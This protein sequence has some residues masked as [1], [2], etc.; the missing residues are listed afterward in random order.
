MMEP[1]RCVGCSGEV[2]AG[3]V[4]TPGGKKQRAHPRRDWVRADIL[5]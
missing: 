2:L 5:L 1:Q 3:A 4:M